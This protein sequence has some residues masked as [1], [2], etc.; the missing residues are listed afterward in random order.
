M[1][2]ACRSTIPTQLGTAPRRIDKY[3]GGYKAAEWTQWLCREGIPI[4]A[5]VVNIEKFQP[6]LLHFALLKKIYLTATQRIITLLQLEQ[7]D[8]DCKEFVRGWQ[9]LYYN[10]QPEHVRN[11]KI[12][13]HTLL[14]LGW[15]I[16]F[17]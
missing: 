1:Q 17:P 8:I 15:H 14:H 10:G 9:K 3:N 7:L 4:L 12:N 5:S 16:M 11:M 2:D 13:L 6:Y